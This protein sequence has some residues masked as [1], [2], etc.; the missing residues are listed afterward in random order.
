MN[1]A[2]GTDGRP[3]CLTL[4][5]SAWTAFSFQVHYPQRSRKQDAEV[6]KTFAYNTMGIG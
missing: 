3:P 6:K 2:G 4:A 5:A 1:A